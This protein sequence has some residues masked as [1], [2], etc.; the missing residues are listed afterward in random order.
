MY[1]AIKKDLECCHEQI[2]VFGRDTKIITNKAIGQY[3]IVYVHAMPDTCILLNAVREI[4][5]L[6]NFEE[7]G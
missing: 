4:I 6:G 2:N 3:T 7:H 1:A 5:I